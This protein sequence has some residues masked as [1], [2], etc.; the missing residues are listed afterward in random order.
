MF[1]VELTTTRGQNSFVP[2]KIDELTKAIS[3]STEI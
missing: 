2:T 1:D 3:E